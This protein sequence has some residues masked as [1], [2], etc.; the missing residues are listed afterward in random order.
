MAASRQR[1]EIWHKGNLGDGDDA[2]TSNTRIAQRTRDNTFDDG[3]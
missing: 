2:G 1:N 3:E